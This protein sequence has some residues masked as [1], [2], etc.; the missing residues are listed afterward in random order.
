LFQHC[1]RAVQ[2]TGRE[3]TLRER[4]QF[5]AAIPV[6]SRSAGAYST[7]TLPTSA[8]SGSILDA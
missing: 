4:K 3:C 5:A 6:C 8:S 2:V 7:L 1:D